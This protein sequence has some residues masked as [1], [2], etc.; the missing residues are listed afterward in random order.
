M[1]KIFRWIMTAAGIAA[2]G[3]LAAESVE[4]YDP[5]GKT[6]ATCSVYCAYAGQ[7]TLTSG[8]YVVSGVITNGTRITVNGDANLILRDS[9]ELAAM[10]GVTV[11][12]K[13][14][15]T[16]SLTIWAQSTNSVAGKL[17]AT[18]KDGVSGIGG[19]EEGA[20]GNVTINGGE[21]TAKGGRF[22]AGIGGGEEGAGGNVT[23][24]GG[25]V[26]ATGGVL[27]AGIGGGFEGM[28]GNV[29]ING[30]EVTATGGQF[31]AGIGGGSGSSTDGELDIS[32]LIVGYAD[33]NGNVTSWA[34]TLE[35]QRVYCRNREG[36]TVRLE[37]C[38][39]KDDDGDG[40]CDV[41][42]KLFGPIRYYDPVGKTNATC[43]VYCAYTNQTTLTSGWYVV[44]GVIT[45][46]TR[47]FVDGDANL[48]LRDNSELAAMSGVNVDVNNSITN[49]LTI[50]A[51]S[52]NSVAGKIS[53]TGDGVYAGIGGG[54][55]R[56]GGTVTINGGKV[57]A[58]GVINGAGIGG[59]NGGAGGTVTINCGT[60]SAAGG[61]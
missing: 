1:T 37:V 8:W 5:V 15:I 47:I 53:A 40:V 14:S 2:T 54:E 46:G 22:A 27:A 31:G 7:T 28:G 60:V 23:I 56:A 45:N 11:D 18:G 20:G 17:T 43:S 29:T 55:N 30:G 44:S 59:G 4:Y 50:W 49:S 3:A 52:T 41:C 10:R 25:E 33:G 42:G 13:S 26:T 9:S 57:S 16:N 34:A 48:I 6:N 35:E 39:H 19:G 38:E 61:G 12:V 32:D 58:E 21:V 36:K 24:N 51:Q